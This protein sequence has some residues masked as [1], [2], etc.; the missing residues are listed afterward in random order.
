MK[1]TLNTLVWPVLAAPLAFLALT[2]NKLP[3]KVPIHFNLEGTPDHFGR[4]QEL[5]LMTAILT[6]ITKDRV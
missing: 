2:W 4:K 3:E 6:A 5:I 1:K